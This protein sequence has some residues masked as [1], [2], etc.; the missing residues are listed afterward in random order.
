M[1]YSKIINDLGWSP[2]YTSIEK[3]VEDFINEV[4]TKRIFIME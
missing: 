2:A 3:I 1:N 4:Q